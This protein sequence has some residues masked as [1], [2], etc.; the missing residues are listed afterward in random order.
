MKFVSETDYLCWY[1][2]PDVCNLMLLSV[3]RI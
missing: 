1:A 3:V 2:V